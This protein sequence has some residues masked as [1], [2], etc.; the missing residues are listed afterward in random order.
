MHKPMI[1]LF[2]ALLMSLNLQFTSAQT[3]PNTQAKPKPEPAKVIKTKSGL[4]YVDLVIG[5]GETAVKGDLLKMHYAGKLASGKEF[6]NSRNYREPFIFT[7]GAGEVIAGWDEGVVGMKVGGKRKLIIP[8][9]LAY[10]DQGVEGVIPPKATLTF[11]VELLSV[12][13]RTPGDGKETITESGLRYVDI[14]IGSGEQP[15]TGN[16]VVV[17]YTGTLENGKKFDSSL[18]RGQPFE[19]VL[20]R[21]Q[22]IK[23]WDEGLATMRVGSKRKLIIPPDLGYGERGAGGAIPPNSTL[24]FEVELLDIKK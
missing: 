15:K 3:K 16:T 7:L 10:G 14:M 17:H 24:I 12:V 2:A 11:E 1:M 21:G 5:K 22:V 20:G 6:D 19:F 9:H 23:G 13:H 8:P 4:Q 18:D